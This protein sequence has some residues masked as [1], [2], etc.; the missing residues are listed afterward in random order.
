MN[1]Y[2]VDNG[3]QAGPVDDAQLEQL[4][5]TGKIQPDTLIWSEGMANWQ[6]YGQVK[7]GS[8]AGVG[9]PPLTG[10]APAPGAGEAVCAECGRVFPQGEVIRYG[11]KSVCA[12]C[13]PVFFQ[14]VREGA[15]FVGTGGGVTEA[16]LLARDYE[17][18]I[19]GSF[20]RAWELFKAN[21]GLLIGGSVLVYLCIMGG[22]M[23]PYLGIIVGLIVGGPLM[24]GLWYFYLKHVRR[25]EATIGDA[26][27]GF[28]PQFWQLVLARIIPGLLA[29]G[30]VMLFGIVAALIIPTMVIGRRGST[31]AT[32]SH[33]AAMFIPLG[34]L[35]FVGV[36]LMMY[37]NTCWIFALP[38][39][40]DKG[41]RFWP[42]MQLSRRVVSKHWWGT[43][44]LLIVAGLFGMVG[45]FACLLGLLVTGPVAFG[46]LT[47][48]Y[49]KV[50]GD[51][52]PSRD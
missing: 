2:Y 49:E 51:L 45:A 15:S 5:Q 19:G 12:A 34:I 23:I 29:A 8:A 33:L 24:G 27:S 31:A 35:L 44:A 50:F 37:L 28:G 25:Q 38:L 17:V 9:A 20:S 52:I 10:A 16:E 21:A 26:F 1:W 40:R 48:H 41:L 43:F 18:D 13:K 46:M 42:A 22:S 11:D 7:A 30:V 4:R 32:S 47:Y 14:R 3:Q 36:L 39:V 6:A